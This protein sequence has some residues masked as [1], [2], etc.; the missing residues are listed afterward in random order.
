MRTGYS[1]LGM[2]SVSV[3]L[4]KAAPRDASGTV[5]PGSALSDT[6]KKLIVDGLL[7]TCDDDDGVADGMIFDPHACDFDPTNSSARARRTTACLNSAQASA[8]QTALVG[9]ESLERPAGVSGLSLRHRHH[10]HAAPA[11]PAC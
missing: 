11:S 2:R 9:A 6:D 3:A 7:K 1:N 8:V 5:I 4:A 10:V